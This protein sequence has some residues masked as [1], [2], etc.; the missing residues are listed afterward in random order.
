MSGFLQRLSEFA[1][2]HFR[3]VRWWFNSALAAKLTIAFTLNAL[4][5]LGF[6]ALIYYL[7]KTGQ[8]LGQNLEFL[9]ILIGA[10]SL[11]VLLYGLYISYLTC[12]P[13][14]QS[15]N[16]AKI[17]A[18]GDLTP[19]LSCLS[20]KDEIGQLCIALNTMVRSF[21]TLV[22]GISG[23]ARVFAES[24]DNLVS[25][26]EN[27]SQSADQINQAINQVATG[28]QDQSN[29]VQS[30]L[31]TIEEMIKYVREIEQSVN[32]AD[33]A[34]L[35]ALEV[36]GDGEK[37]ITRAGNQMLSI[38]RTVNDTSAI[39]HEL[40]EKS[41]RIGLIAEAIKSISDQTNLLALNAAIEAA[42]AGEHGR[43]F[44]VVA[45]EVRKLA[46]Q[47]TASSG[48][49]EQ[50]IQEIKSSVTKAI[51]T[52]KAEEEVVRE[53]AAVIQESQEAFNRITGSS[54]IVNSQISEV[55]SHTRNIVSSAQKVTDEVNQVAGIIQET[56]AQSEEVASSSTAQMN[57]MMDI[58]TA[59]E[60][61]SK[62][63]GELNTQVQ[64]FFLG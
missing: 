5:I 33:Q 57:S 10:A 24:A 54:R 14:R 52:T 47:S 59:A 34:S 53:G 4:I 39:I 35:Q 61:L 28:S 60:E 20:Q 56:T 29:S 46:E 22:E 64:K 6:G 17:I 51:N 8:D 31:L 32:L 7:V 13:L 58:N 25:Q 16:F 18:G 19:E 1:Y 11:I 2:K 26:A 49:I 23:G 30:I 41:E 9:L 36:A 42:R 63:A 15:V 62:V 45:E 27:T 44:S 50:I 43:G 40:G 38:Q 12:V 3:V 48:E 37:D 55:T 21:R